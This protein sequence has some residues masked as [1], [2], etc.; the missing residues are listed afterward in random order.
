MTYAIPLLVS[1]AISIWF[2]YWSISV[3]PGL[4]SRSCRI[5]CFAIPVSL[6]APLLVFSDTI[7]A[8]LYDAMPLPLFFVWLGGATGEFIITLAII[9]TLV[10]LL[11]VA[12]L[13]EKSKPNGQ[14]MISQK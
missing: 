10:T 9:E 4:R 8:P 14:H 13:G 7:L 5:A 6:A 2:C 1:C 11:V 12:L 3:Y